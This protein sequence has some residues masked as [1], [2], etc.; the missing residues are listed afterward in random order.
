MRGRAQGSGRA[1][2]GKGVLWV[3]HGQVM[4][5]QE[6]WRQGRKGVDAQAVCGKWLAEHWDR[7]TSTSVMMCCN[8]ASV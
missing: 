7:F 8:A 2:W 5:Q 3:L 1:S 4:R 6:L